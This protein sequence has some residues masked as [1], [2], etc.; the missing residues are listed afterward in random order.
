MM[1]IECG[2]MLYV[3]TPRMLFDRLG[4]DLLDAVFA[5]VNENSRFASSLVCKAFR[6]RYPAGMRFR[7]DVLAMNYTLSLL[8]WAASMPVPCPQ[9]KCVL[10]LDDSVKVFNAFDSLGRLPVAVLALHAAAVVRKLSDPDVDVRFMALDNLGK[11][12]SDM[13]MQHASSIVLA[14]EDPDA[15]VRYGAVNAL[16]KLEPVAL[17]FYRGAIYEM[18]NDSDMGV[19]LAALKVVRKIQSLCCA[20]HATSI[21]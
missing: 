9:L 6:A 4:I 3:A 21:A 10:L 1:D 20:E 11:L 14:L 2:E 16:G 15:D 18:C 17:A 13:L 5:F 8:T 12:D 19:Q 7:T